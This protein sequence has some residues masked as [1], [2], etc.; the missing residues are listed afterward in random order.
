[1]PISARVLLDSISESGH[2][3]TTME[4]VCPNIIWPEM[5]THRAFSRSTSSN[6]AIPAARMIKMVEDDPFIPMVWPRNQPGMR[7]GELLPFE[8][9]VDAQADWCEALDA[10]LDAA[11]AMV[12]RDV[13]KS[14]VNRLLQPFGWTTAI[15]SS[16]EWDNFF[17]QRCSPLA[18]YHMMLTA[19]A[20]KKAL[21]DSKPV[22]Y[23]AGGWHCPLTEDINDEGWPLVK[24]ISAARCARVSYLTHDGKRDVAE[25]LKLYERLRS[26]NPPHWSPMEHVATPAHPHDRVEGNFTGWHQFRHIG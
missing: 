14:I 6:R 17:A 20:M 3:L 2:R 13:H 1:M 5:L 23:Y 25:D 7:G 9:A 18:E 26:A 16:T 15:I 4:V 21:E 22:T 8:D 19:Q 11:K 24:R 10:S 12:I